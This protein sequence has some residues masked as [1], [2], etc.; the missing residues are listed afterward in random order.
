MKRRREVKNNPFRESVFSKL[1][2]F[3]SASAVVL[4]SLNFNHGN[5]SKSTSSPVTYTSS[6][7]YDFFYWLGNYNQIFIRQNI[8]K[9][10]THF[11]QYF[12]SIFCINVNSDNTTY[13]TRCP[14]YIFVNGWN[15]GILYRSIMMT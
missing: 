7:K 4:F 1:L 13:K 8:F 2:F 9:I 3:R 11:Y 15:I 5:H 12:L 10:E 6:Y 14:R